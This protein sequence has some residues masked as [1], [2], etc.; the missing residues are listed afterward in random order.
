MSVDDRLKREL[1]V[2]G[3]PAI[4]VPF[5]R[6]MVDNHYTMKRLDRKEE[7]AVKVAERRANGLHA[8]AGGGAGAQQPR[9]AGQVQP[10][11][12]ENPGDVYDEL[13]DLRGRTDCQFCHTVIE[14]LMDA[15]PSEARVGYDELRS[16]VR[17]VERIE[18]RDIS[19]AQAEQ[20]V[21]QLVEGWEVVP[22]YVAGSV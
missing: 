12:F 8:M 17:E 4:A 2:T 15:P 11:T 21:S 1:I 19:Q 10:S 20:L 13:E 3:V 14:N 6:A 7:M 16:Y 5:I 9:P 18:E 22:K